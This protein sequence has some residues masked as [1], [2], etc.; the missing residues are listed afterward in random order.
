MDWERTEICLSKVSVLLLGESSW[1]SVWP[2]RANRGIICWKEKI[3]LC[4]PA[5]GSGVVR[6]CVVCLRWSGNPGSGAEQKM[7]WFDYQIWFLSLTCQGV[8][9]TSSQ[10]LEMEAFNHCINSQGQG[11]VSGNKSSEC[12]YINLWLSRGGRPTTNTHSKQW[13]A[14]HSHSSNL[15]KTTVLC[16]GG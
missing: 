5:L 4:S 2:R 9:L 10:A 16:L 8:V 12:S 7:K 3:C 6:I 13:Q 15:E 11:Y 1:R 14:A